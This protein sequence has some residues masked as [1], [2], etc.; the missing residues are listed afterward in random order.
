MPTKKAKVKKERTLSY[1]NKFLKKEIK[2]KPIEGEVVASLKPQTQE[3]EMLRNLADKA[4]EVSEGYNLERGFAILKVS[5][6][7]RANN[8]GDMLDKNPDVLNYLPAVKDDDGL[9]RYFLPDEFTVQFKEDVSK[10]QAK[11]ILEAQDCPILEEQRTEGYYTVAVPEGK[12]LFEMLNKFSELADVAFAEPSEVSTNSMDLIPGDASFNLLWGLRNT[13]QTV[14]SVSGTSDADIDATEAWDIT[15]GDPD[16]IVAVIDTGCDLNHPDLA[17]NLLPRGTEDWDFADLADPSPDDLNGHGTHVS[18]TVAAVNNT[19]GVLGVAPKCKIMPL[20]VNLTAGLNQNRADAINYVAGRATANPG[21]RYVINCSWRMNGDHAGVRNAIQNAVA[22]N[23]VVVFAAGN[24][25]TNVDVTPQYPGIYPEVI[26]VAA[27][28]QSDTRAS[29]SNFGTKVDVSA[30]G[31]NIFSTLPDDT[32]T[33]MDGTSMASP[34]V[35]GLA[36]LIWSRNEGLTNAQVRSIIETTCDNIDARNPGFVGLLGKGRINAFSALKATPPPILPFQVVRRFRFPQ[37]NAGSSSTL[38]FVKRFRVGGI[39]RPVLMFLT[40][41]AF[42][43]PIFYLNPANGAVL[44]SVVPAGNQ[45]IGSLDWDGTNIRVANVTTGSGFINTVNPFTGA[46]LASMAVPPGRG[47]AMAITG[48]RVYYS[49][50]GRIYK[51]NLSTGAVEGS[52]LSPGS[53][54][55]ALAIRNSSLLRPLR[56]FSCKSTTGEIFVINPTT[57]FIHGIMNAPGGGTAQCE[58]LAYDSTNNELYVANQSENMIYVCK[59]GF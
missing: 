30:P 45:T 53:E 27:T 57:G 32:H 28:G 39:V 11:K 12:G 20:R 59:L 49:N 40:Q 58:G 5:E 48:S 4:M 10:A 54:C 29:F 22:R 13:G 42:S 55:R 9:T 31:V 21:K 41:R 15:Q 3:N 52:I 26:S 33:F 37:T 8:G 6:I 25:N 44:G 16:V 51:I 34:H 24:A 36:A 1:T 50:V 35:A 19:I 38:A 14:N 46:Q 7:A 43:E 2:F 47:E 17:V 18:G 56:L 23:V